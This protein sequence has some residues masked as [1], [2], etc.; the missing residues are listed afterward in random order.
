MSRNNRSSVAYPVHEKRRQQI[1][2]KLYTEINCYEQGYPAQWYTVA[3]L[4]GNEQQR[5]KVIYYRLNDIA[6][7]TGENCFVI[8][9]MSAPKS[10]FSY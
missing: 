1:H 2:C 8:V 9:H 3:A 7:K 4:Q 6:C 10:F 5:Y